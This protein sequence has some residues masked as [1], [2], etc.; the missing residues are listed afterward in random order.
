MPYTLSADV[1]ERPV[2]IVGAGTLG[3]R[4]ALVYAAGG[5]DVRILPLGGAA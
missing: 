2:S 4:L 3:R 1:D 5:S